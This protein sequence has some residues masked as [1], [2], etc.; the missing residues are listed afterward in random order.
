MLTK[1][2]NEM[3]EEEHIQRGGTLQ[4]ARNHNKNEQNL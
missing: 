2:E 4:C 1:K 3:E